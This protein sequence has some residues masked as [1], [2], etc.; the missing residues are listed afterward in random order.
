MEHFRDFMK[1]V[2]T[3]SMGEFLEQFPHPFLFYSQTPGAMDSFA[4]TR[5]VS[6]AEGAESIDRFSE[7]VLDFIPLLPNPRPSR[8]FPEKSFVGRDSKRDFVIQHST[9]SNRHACLFYDTDES[10]HKLVD[11]GSTNGTMVRGR[12]LVPGEPVVLRD[13]DVVTFGQMDFL[14]F[15]PK[16]AYRFM[17]QYRL[18]RE[19]MKD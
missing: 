3:M 8:D 17:H 2:A 9:V 18:F 11:S 19:A 6:H 7:Q 10:T 4:H 13:G 5:L 16:G 15:S 14:F 12:A 1:V